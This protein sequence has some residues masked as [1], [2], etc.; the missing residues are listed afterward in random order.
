MSSNS[1]ITD[2]GLAHIKGL[3]GLRSIHLNDTLVSDAGLAYLKGMSRL[4]TLN[5]AGTRVT[6]DGVLELERALPRVQIHREEEMVF[7]KKLPSAIDDLDFA[8]TQPIRLASWLLAERARVIASNGN[9]VEFIATIDA[10]CSLEANDKLSLIK[11]AQHRAGCL[12]ILDP[13]YSPN[14]SASERLAL[15]QQCADRAI[16][17]LRLAVE[18]GYNN[19]PHLESERSSCIIPLNLHDHPD[20][21]KLVGRMK[22]MRPGR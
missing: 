7:L 13:F 5:L 18:Q 22:A 12:G 11:L 4:E 16:D 21:P 10:L 2:A 6:D 9:K 19:L 17:A 3:I 15:K 20:F 14:L 8:R 1:A